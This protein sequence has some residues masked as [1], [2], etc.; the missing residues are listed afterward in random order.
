MDIKVTRYRKIIAVCPENH[1]KEINTP[2]CK[3]RSFLILQ[4]MGHV[5]TMA[6][7]TNNVFSW[8]YLHTLYLSVRSWETFVVPEH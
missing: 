1:S 2:P 3:F 4:Q 6:G 8:R 5:I 7:E